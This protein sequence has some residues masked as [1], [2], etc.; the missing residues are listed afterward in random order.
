MQAGNTRAAGHKVPR[1][2]HHDQS[3]SG[4]RGFT[5]NENCHAAANHVGYGT[6]LFKRCENSRKRLSLG[7]TRKNIANGVY[8]WLV[9]SIGGV[10]R[11]AQTLLAAGLNTHR[12]LARPP[13]S[14]A[15]RHGLHDFLFSVCIADP[16]SG[17]VQ[18]PILDGGCCR[19]RG[20]FRSSRRPEAKSSRRGYGQARAVGE[21]AK[22]CLAVRA[23]YER[24]V[25]GSRCKN[26]GCGPSCR[27]SRPASRTGDIWSAA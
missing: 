4:Q 13:I 9:R 3:T 10:E 19:K 24:R 5:I 8:G 20:Y 18:E 14:C 16:M 26:G 6:K 27:E 15:R 23:S 2:T 12:P 25:P 21:I 1:P 17:L 11:A 7:M 22:R